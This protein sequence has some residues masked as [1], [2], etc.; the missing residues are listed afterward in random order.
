[1]KPSCEAKNVDTDEIVVE[2][3]QQ[4]IVVISR[5]QTWAEPSCAEPFLIEGT[6]IINHINCSILIDGVKYD[7]TELFYKEKIKL[8]LPAVKNITIN[9]TVENLNLDK[10]VFHL[11]ENNAKIVRVKQSTT[12]L[13][14][15]T[16]ISAVILVIFIIYTLVVKRKITYLPNPA[17][18]VNYVSPIPSLWPSLHSRGGGVT[19]SAIPTSSSP[20]P[21]PPRANC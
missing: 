11:Q 19:T 14:F 15:L 21:K 8:S 5:N 7:D 1:M 9:A 10:I 20:P 16:Y 13:R 6:T 17:P 12:D 18:S 4:W 3:E 2:P